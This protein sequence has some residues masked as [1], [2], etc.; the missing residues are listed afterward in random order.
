MFTGGGTLRTVGRQRDK[1]IKLLLQMVNGHVAHQPVCRLRI[2]G[3]SGGEQL[4]VTFKAKT[5]IP[6]RTFADTVLQAF[7]FALQGMQRHQ[8]F[9]QRQAG[10]ERTRR[11]DTGFLNKSAVGEERGRH[12]GPPY[13]QH[14]DSG[15]QCGTQP[16]K[17]HRA[18]ARV[19]TRHARPDR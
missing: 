11:L 19:I 15:H 6:R 1:G 5:L 16:R 8:L 3:K 12:S 10:I 2:A 13:H 7:Q 9:C 14:A 18:P 17:T 4:L